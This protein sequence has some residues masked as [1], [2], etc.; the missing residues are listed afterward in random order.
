MK[1]FLAK[2]ALPEPRE[3]LMFHTIHMPSI[4]SDISVVDN[5]H[6]LWRLLDKATGWTIIEYSREKEPV[7]LTNLKSQYGPYFSYIQYLIGE[8]ETSRVRSFMPRLNNTVDVM[9]SDNRFLFR[10][11]DAQETLSNV[12]AFVKLDYLTLVVRE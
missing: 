11:N 10:L 5:E 8:G 4:K 1:S 9:L 2:Y 6:D 3:D 12:S 7:S